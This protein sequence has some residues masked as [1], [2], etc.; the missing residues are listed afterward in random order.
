MKNYITKVFTMCIHDL[1]FLR[2]LIKVDETCR[3]YGET[4]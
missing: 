4:K 2:R 3:M 1:I